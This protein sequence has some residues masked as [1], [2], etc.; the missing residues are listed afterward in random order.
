MQD[1]D[2]LRVAEKTVHDLDRATHRGLHPIHKRYPLL[3]LFLLTFS[4]AAIFHGLD[5]VLDTIPFANQFPWTL[6]LIGILGLFS[7]GSLYKRL[8]KD[9]FD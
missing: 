4:V 8:G 1:I 6:I 2:P 3:F 5:R 7:T 9:K